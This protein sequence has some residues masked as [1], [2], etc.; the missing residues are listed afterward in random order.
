MAASA[1]VRIKTKSVIALFGYAISTPS[2]LRLGDRHFGLRYLRLPSVIQFAQK[3]DHHISD[4]N[5]DCQPDHLAWNGSDKCRPAFH[6]R[7]HNILIFEF[8]SSLSFPLSLVIHQ[9]KV[10]SV[11]IPF[12]TPFAIGSMGH[13]YQS[14]LSCGDVYPKQ[15]CLRILIG[16]ERFGL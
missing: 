4:N 10:N 11:P 9:G 1:E 14:F 5:G 16:Q 15:N 13:P 12:F 2:A 8:T 7:P 6:T 3:M